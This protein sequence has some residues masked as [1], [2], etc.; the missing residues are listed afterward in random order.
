MWPLRWCEL[1][2]FEGFHTGPSPRMSG[3]MRTLDC[4]HSPQN[5]CDGCTEFQGSKVG[6]VAMS[7]WLG[8]CEATG[9]GLSFAK[10]GIDRIS[11]C[12]NTL[13]AWIL[14]FQAQPDAASYTGDHQDEGDVRYAFTPIVQHLCHSAA[15]ELYGKGSASRNICLFDGLMVLHCY[16]WEVQT[17]SEIFFLQTVQ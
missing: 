11:T 3:G 6:S 17:H 15:Y 10:C 9:P 14:C 13:G 5:L 2:L 4:H 1:Q 7:S 16:M 12:N 8:H